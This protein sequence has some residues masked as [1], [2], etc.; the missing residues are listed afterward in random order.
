M[1]CA[2][3]CIC[4]CTHVL[5]ITLVLSFVSPTLALPIVSRDIQNILQ[6]SAI[7]ENLGGD[8]IVVNSETSG[9]I[10]QGTATDGGGTGYDAPAL[11]WLIVS[12]ALGVPLAFAG[13]RGWR[14]TLGAGIGLAVGVCGKP[15]FYSHSPRV[16][17]QSR[18]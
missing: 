9:L 7:I 10:A 13:V 4:L 16:F 15:S 14:L 2:L 3:S 5:Y 11:I 18:Y 1:C 12:F 6:R 17:L 8:I